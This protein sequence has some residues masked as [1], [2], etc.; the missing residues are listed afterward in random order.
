MSKIISIVAVSI[1]GFGLNGACI[2]NNGSVENGYVMTKELTDS[3][4]TDLNYNSSVINSSDVTYSGD[5]LTNLPYSTNQYAHYQGVKF[6]ITDRY[7]LD[8]TF[9]SRPSDASTQSTLPYFGIAL[10]VTNSPDYIQSIVASSSGQNLDS[11]YATCD[12]EVE[13]TI[14]AQTQQNITVGGEYL[15]ASIEASLSAFEEESFGIG[16]GTSISVSYDFDS[17]DS[18]KTYSLYKTVFQYRF[19]IMIEY[20]TSSSY[21]LDLNNEKVY[22]Y[23]YSSMGLLTDTI[24]TSQFEIKV[25]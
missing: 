19:L 22:Y 5:G 3:V 7:S 21:Y 12:K 24:S 8:D 1:V 15:G 6:T 13:Q 16:S 10:F 11:L 9:I 17:T 18:S 4:I 2:S 20:P 25:N 23:N 14:S